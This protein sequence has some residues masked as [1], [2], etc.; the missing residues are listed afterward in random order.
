M[1]LNRGKGVKITVLSKT[2]KADKMPDIA[3]FVGAMKE[4]GAKVSTKGNRIVINLTLG[5]KDA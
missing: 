3:G 5:G 1:K 4:M 2:I